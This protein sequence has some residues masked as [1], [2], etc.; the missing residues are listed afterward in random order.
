R[1]AVLTSPPPRR[2]QR[3]GEVP[4]VG[5]LPRERLARRERGHVRGPGDPAELALETAGVRVGGHQAR[6]DLADAQ[7]LEELPRATAQHPRGVA[8]LRVLHVDEDSGPHLN[9][10]AR[11]PVPRPPPPPTALPSGTTAAHGRSLRG[12]CRSSFRSSTGPRA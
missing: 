5:I 10:E 6:A 1:S 8:P 11:R 7:P 9:A 3:D 12:S 2:V 4:E